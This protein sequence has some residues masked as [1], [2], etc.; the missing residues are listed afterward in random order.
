MNN[1]DTAGCSGQLGGEVVISAA[2]GS[3]D[4]ARRMSQH[5]CS[6]LAAVAARPTARVS[7]LDLL[8]P[9]D[10]QTVLHAFNDT[11][12]PIPKLCVQQL[13]EQ[14]A[15]AQPHVT[16][17]IDSAAGDSLTYAQ[18]NSAA[19][20]LARH[21]VGAGV[22]TDVPVAVLMDKCPEAYIALIAI[23]KAGGEGPARIKMLGYAHFLYCCWGCILRFKPAAR[24]AWVLLR[25]PDNACHCAGC[26]QPI[27]HTLPAARIADVLQQSGA[28]ILLVSSA[29]AGIRDS[30][31]SV[32]TV[33]AEPEWRQFSHLSPSNQTQRS[34]IDS[35]IFVLFTSG[36]CHV[37]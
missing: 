21:L 16:C 3:A 32:E 35:A 25:R 2:L 12:S 8:T 4:T 1:A 37:L 9:E 23:L 5:L 30:L 7:E 20:R 6:L 26:Y 14:Q 33:V 15:A 28:Q 29:L 13:F 18:V 10:R 31:P 36:A 27:D 19:N 17:L 11:G 24:W 34:S 22:A